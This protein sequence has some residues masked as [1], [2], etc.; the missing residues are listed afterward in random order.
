M[1]KEPNIT[2]EIPT[3]TMMVDIPL[4]N[5]QPEKKAEEK[6]SFFQI[7]FSYIRSTCCPTN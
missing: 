3:A 7:L 5:E 2:E 4:D 1:N 6:I